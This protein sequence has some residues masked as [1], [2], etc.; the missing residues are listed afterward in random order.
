MTIIFMLIGVSLLMALGFLMAFVWS[1]K[2][3]Q[4]EDDYTPSVRMLFEDKPSTEKKETSPILN[5]DKN[6]MGL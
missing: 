1:V 4:M 6:Q 2:S 3:G 5:T